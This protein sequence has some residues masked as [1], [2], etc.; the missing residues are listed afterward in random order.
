ML[1]ALSASAQPPASEWPV[2]RNARQLAGGE[3]KLG[4]FGV[5]VGLHRRLQLG[6]QWATWAVAGPNLHLKLMLVEH[7]GWQLA[8]DSSF[9]HVKLD[10]LRWFGLE[11]LTGRLTVFPVELFVDKVVHE[12]WLLGIGTGYALTHASPRYDLDQFSGAGAYDSWIA[13]GSATWRA[14][15]HLWL[16]G[17]LDWI[18]HQRTAA[19]GS[20]EARI[21]DYTSIEGRARLGGAAVEA[22]R[23]G[24]IT[25]S[26]VLHARRFGLRFGLGYGNFVL[27]RTR[28]VIPDAI[29]YFVFDLYGRFGGLKR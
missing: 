14:L 15:P 7:R 23:G 19:A 20:F 18:L 11:D 16:V 1:W 17:E 9:F 13:H 29:P 25:L 26:M 5:D 27:P 8:L 28:L 6:T 21:D 12:R 22:A 3:W 4:L 24:A 10:N 2:E